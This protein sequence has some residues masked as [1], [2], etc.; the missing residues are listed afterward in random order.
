M[1]DATQR[2]SARQGCGSSFHS[3]TSSLNPHHALSVS[4]VPSQ[5]RQPLY[6]T[7][8]RREHSVL[9]THFSPYIATAGSNAANRPHRL[10]RL[11]TYPYRAL[12]LSQCA[13]PSAEVTVWDRSGQGLALGL[14][15]CQAAHRRGE[16]GR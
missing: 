12:L 13:D 8:R 15:R 4:F 6:E 3:T 7:V 1:E 2:N 16:I 10:C 14:P 5:T 9:S 11:R